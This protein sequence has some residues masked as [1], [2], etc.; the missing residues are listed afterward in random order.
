MEI[1]LEV[2]T[3]RKSVGEVRRHWPDEIKAQIVSKSIRTG[4]TMKGVAEWHGLKANH[5]PT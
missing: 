3:I 2:P 5:L 1:T 4:A